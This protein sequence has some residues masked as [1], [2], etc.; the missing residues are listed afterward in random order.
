[1]NNKETISD[2]L[3]KKFC[4]NIVPVLSVIHEVNGRTIRDC[5]LDTEK[6]EDR[7]KSYFSSISPVM[8][9]KTVER[10]QDLFEGSFIIGESHSHISP[11]RVLIEKMKKN[12]G[13]RV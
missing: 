7:I 6:F 8:I 11:K 13:V 2:E 5:C 9:D 4:E 10:V 12:E 3:R 1:M